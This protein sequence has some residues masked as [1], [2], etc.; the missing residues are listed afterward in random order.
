MPNF[1]LYEVIYLYGIQLYIVWLS[2]TVD[3]LYSSLH[4]CA[5]Y[6]TTRGD[7]VLN[8]GTLDFTHDSNIIHRT[9]KFYFGSQ[10]V[11]EEYRTCITFNINV[12]THNTIWAEQSNNN[13]YFLLLSVFFCSVKCGYMLISL[14]AYKT[15][16]Q[17]IVIRQRQ[18]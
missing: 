17:F 12:K 15:L 3:R 11:Q 8:Q 16:T 2:L 13:Y 6:Q 5:Y 18:K 1:K 9:R 14:E 10:E 7:G 4:E